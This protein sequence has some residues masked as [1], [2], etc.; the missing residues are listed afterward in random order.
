MTDTLGDCV[1]C[2]SIAKCSPHK[3]KVNPPVSKLEHLHETFMF[4]IH[5][6]DCRHYNSD[7]DAI[8]INVKHLQ[9]II[10]FKS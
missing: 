10:Y 1:T 9:N 4:I 8:K 2:L 7:L 6:K 5:F 3:G